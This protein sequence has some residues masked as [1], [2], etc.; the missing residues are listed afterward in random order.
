MQIQCN[1]C[2]AIQRFK[3][4]CA[5]VDSLIAFGWNSFGERFYCPE[6]VAGLN[7]YATAAKLF[8]GAENTR[9]LIAEMADKSETP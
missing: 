6:C 5:N 2:G 9:G 4:S 8:K 3:Y 7:G 1:K